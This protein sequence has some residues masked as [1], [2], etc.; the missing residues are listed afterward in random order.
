[1]V[2]LGERPDNPDGKREGDPRRR[3]GRL[4]PDGRR[5]GDVVR[6]RE[7]AAQPDR[8]DPRLAKSG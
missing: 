1:M 8:R 5:P 4:V 6:K 7:R 2:E 3:G